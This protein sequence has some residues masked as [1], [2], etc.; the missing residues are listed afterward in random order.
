MDTSTSI[1]DFATGAL[2]LIFWVTS[3]LHFGV[4]LILGVEMAGF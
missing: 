4:I 2:I 1:I 3:L